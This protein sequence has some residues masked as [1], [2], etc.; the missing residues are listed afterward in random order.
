MTYALASG[1]MGFMELTQD[2]MMAV[3]G[4]GLLGSILGTIGGAAT[5]VVGVCCL[6]IPEPTM[7]TKVGGVATIVAGAAWIGSCWT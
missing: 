7:L 2:E 5:I 3:D 1:N 6:L 4:G